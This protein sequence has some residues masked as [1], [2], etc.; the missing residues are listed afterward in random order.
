MVCAVCCFAYCRILVLKDGKIVE[1]GTHKELLAHNGVF[2]AMWANQV[3]AED[4][5]LSVVEGLAKKEGVVEGYDVDA[6]KPSITSQVVS[7][8][9]M[10]EQF[11]LADTDENSEQRLDGLP[12]LMKSEA[13]LQEAITQAPEILSDEPAPMNESEANDAP[14]VPTSTSYAAAAAA[15][16]GD[17]AAI[18][19]HIPSVQPF[20][21]STAPTVAPDAPV[22]FPISG[23]DTTSQH[24]ASVAEGSVTVSADQ[25]TRAT[26]PSGPSVT[27]GAGV[28]TPPR[29][30]TP[31][32]GGGESGSEPG[33]RK[34]TASQNFQRFA[35]RISIGQIMPKRSGSTTSIPV[36]SAQSPGKSES[37]RPSIGATER[38]RSESRMSFRRTDSGSPA[39]SIAGVGEGDGKKGKKE[40]KDKFRKGSSTGK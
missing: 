24:T 19:H 23:D 15:P 37:G 3:S 40:D 20:P 12:D 1:Q 35:R 21:S 26:S 2:A 9:A 6:I 39:S 7:P 13:G 11:K 10:N 14:I 18:T 8:A 22:A 4:T 27:F 31:D 28:N 36:A 34:R 30:S 38:A 16:P 5:A 32:I 25:S 17:N 33:K 29:S